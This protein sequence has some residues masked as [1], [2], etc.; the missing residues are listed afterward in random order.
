MRIIPGSD[1]GLQKVQRLQFLCSIVAAIIVTSAGPSM[2]DSTKAPTEAK[3]AASSELKDQMQGL[4]SSPK[5]SCYQDEACVLSDIKTAEEKL[6]ACPDDPKLR[7]KLAVLYS[8]SID[9]ASKAKPIFEQLVKENESTDSLMDLASCSYR[10]DFEESFRLCS[11]ALQLNNGVE[12]TPSMVKL[13]LADSR[14]RQNDLKQAEQFYQE[15]LKELSAR[16]VA[17][18]AKLDLSGLAGLYWRQGDYAKSAARYQDLYC[19]D[20]DLYGAADI[21]CGWALLQTSQ[22]LSKSGQDP[23]LAN[24][25]WNRALWLFRKSNADRILQ[26]YQKAH[27]SVPA[28]V[29]QNV[30]QSVFVSSIEPPDPIPATKSEYTAITNLDLQNFV[31]PWKRKFKQTEAPGWVWM[32]PDVPVKSILICVHGLGLHHRAYDSF[33]RR[34]A[35]EGILTIAFDVRGFGTYMEAAGQER[36]DMDDCVQDLKAIIKQLRKDYSKF[37]FFLLGESMGGALAL[38]VVAES[39]DSVDGLICSVPSGERYKALGTSLKVGTDYLMNK[40]RPIPVGLDVIK[41]ATTDSALRKAWVH[42]PSSRI[43]ISPAELLNFQRFMNESSIY[44]KKITAKPVI[45]FQGHDDKLVKESGTLELF[46]ALS[47]KDKSVVILGNTEHLIFEA[48]QYKDDVTLGL[49][50]WM[51]ANFPEPKFPESK[52]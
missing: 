11:K 49:L 6:K 13:G 8:Q 36:L 1:S 51:T 27:G 26:E 28:N 45:L 35:R 40:K 16:D 32:D 2:A 34:I 18:V 41:Q 31:C 43:N 33:A 37:P 5:Q 52:P 50:G 7:R 44:A 47:T 4:E 42:D 25:C 39:P 12:Y 46:D 23:E 15:S 19:L 29:L 38:R 14:Y 17:L 24:A 3:E 10:V 22:A 9:D 48:G 20:R 30:Q 21:E